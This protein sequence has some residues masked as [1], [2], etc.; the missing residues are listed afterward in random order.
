MHRALKGSRLIFVDEGEGHGV[1][2]SSGNKCAYAGVNAY[3]STG[4]LPSADVTCKADPQQPAKAS[5]L[6]TPPFPGL[7]NRF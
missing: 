6:P 2:G 1:Y 3:L 7:P 4:T 5:L